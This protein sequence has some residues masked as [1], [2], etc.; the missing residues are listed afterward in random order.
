MD[1]DDK[2]TEQGGWWYFK[3]SSILLQRQTSSRIIITTTKTMKQ[4]KKKEFWYDWLCQFIGTS[5]T[6]V[7]KK[8]L[9]L[10]LRYYHYPS[11]FYMD[12]DYKS[13][14]LKL[15]TPS[16][17]V[18]LFYGNSKQKNI[19]KQAREIWSC[20]VVSKFRRKIYMMHDYHDLYYRYYN[21]L[22]TFK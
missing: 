13:C 19:Y 2:K 14:Y 6:H 15:H 9:L 7:E 12:N 20:V 11:F 3:H 8:S 17:V 21:L 18:G 22:G 1:D 16:L 5:S 4:E 10:F